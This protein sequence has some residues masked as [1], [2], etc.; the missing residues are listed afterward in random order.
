MIDVKFVRQEIKQTLL[1]VKREGMPE[2]VAFLDKTDYYTA[3]AST[4]YHLSNKHGLMEHHYN[5]YNAMLEIRKLFNLTISDA[6]LIIISLLHDVC[7]VG[8]YKKVG[9][10]YE[11]DKEVIKRGHAKLTLE[12][13]KM[14]IKLTEEEEMVI[15]FHMGTFGVKGCYLINEY[16]VEEMH[17]AIAKYPLVQIF[18]SVDMGCGQLEKNPKVEKVVP[19]E[20]KK[21]TADNIFKKLEEMDS[22]HGVEL[23]TLKA[24]FDDNDKFDEIVDAMKNQGDV[25]EVKRG[26][27]KKL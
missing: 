9:D 8:L 22:P 19:D 27:I 16:S 18:A 15:K 4:K 17:K 2:L 24:T 1:S 3:P 12:R 10:I 6:T 13:I 25:F 7:K 20:T 11:Y 23:E 5:L 21:L 26:F 14:F